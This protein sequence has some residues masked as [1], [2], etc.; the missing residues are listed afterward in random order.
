MENDVQLPDDYDRI[1]HDIEPFWGIR[2]A[3]LRKLIAEHESEP[4]T[5]TLGNHEGY[6]EIFVVN[7]SG[8]NR[9]SNAAK[10][11]SDDQIWILDKVKQFL[12]PFRA[13]FTVSLPTPHNPAPN[14]PSSFMMLVY[15]SLDTT[16]VPRLSTQL[17]WVIVSQP[18]Q[19]LD[20]PLTP[21]RYRH[22]QTMG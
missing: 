14:S 4:G 11:R 12:P 20:Q 9:D 2:P 21:Y 3:D 8:V 10:E 7:S 16:F 19:P 17:L 15:S 18:F 6:G 5:Y 13:T 1:Y 22:R